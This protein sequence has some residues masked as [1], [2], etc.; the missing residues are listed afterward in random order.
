MTANKRLF[1]EKQGEKNDSKPQDLRTI[2]A[3]ILNLEFD[4]KKIA[5]RDIILKSVFYGKN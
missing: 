5:L 4:L 2:S 3:T 1:A